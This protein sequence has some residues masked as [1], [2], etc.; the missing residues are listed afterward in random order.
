MQD[1]HHQV[2]RTLFLLT[3]GYFLWLLAVLLIFGYT[4]TNDGVG[5]IEYAEYCL[6][7]AQP[8][9][10]TDIYN[11]V[12]F[13]WNIGII[14]LA[15]L[16]LRLTNAIWP[17][18]LLMCILKSAIC[19][20]TGLIAKQL[21]SERIAIIAMI[22]FM[23]YPNN[24]GQSTMISSEIPSTCLAM[25]AVWIAVS[26]RNLFLAGITLALANWFRP[27]AAIFLVSIVL[28]IIIIYRS[29]CL[30]SIIKIIAGYVLFIALIGTSCYLRTGHFVYQA[31]SYWFSMVDECYD[32]A[33]VAPHWGQ[34]IWPEGTP[35]YI[36]NH[37]QMNCFDFERIWRQR[38]LDWLKDHP[39]EYLSKIPGRLYYLYQ[40]DYDNMTVFLNDKSLPE[41]NYITIPIRHLATE[42]S[43]MSIAQWLALFS[44]LI[45]IL[46][47]LLAI[48]GTVI[49][50]SQR[51]FKALFLPL[52]IVVGGSL[53]LVLVMHGETRFKDPL[54]PLLFILAAVGLYHIS[55][56]I[57]LLKNGK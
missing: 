50:V 41:N 40:S 20:L 3:A 35:R 11:V 34:P 17:V 12:P 24:W 49:L 56:K 23:L 10:T 36:E 55:H 47:L 43:T 26:Q 14:N 51:Q 39:I 38:S 7:Q 9:P 29:H 18:L 52:F 57:R 27:T 31:R 2:N 46:L 16:S 48:K 15:E 33:E 25:T 6:K 42:A 21:F 28:Y 53:A 30:K 32:G 4:P 1:C 22:L 45:Y 13:I 5:Y 8:Y 37:E 44:L 19:L 54:M